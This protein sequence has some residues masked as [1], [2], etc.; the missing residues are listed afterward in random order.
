MGVILPT[1][2]NNEFHLT[3]ES[4]ITL[5][6]FVLRYFITKKAFERY[7]PDSF[8]IKHQHIFQIDKVYFGTFP[9][10]CSGWTA[11]N[12]SVDKETVSFDFINEDE[13]NSGIQHLSALQIADI[14]NKRAEHG[15]KIVTI[16]L[17]FIGNSGGIT[18]NTGH[19]NQIV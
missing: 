8:T 13:L 18:A 3:Y 4:D 7:F 2:I 19:Q 6:A 1:P 10:F 11:F 15:F 16:W 5:S 9:K 17:T 14:D 12:V